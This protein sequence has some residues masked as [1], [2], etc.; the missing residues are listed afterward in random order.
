MLAPFTSALRLPLVATAFLCTVLTV[1]IQESLRPAVTDPY[2]SALLAVAP[3]LLYCFGCV[4]AVAAIRVWPRSYAWVI[5][6]GAPCYELLQ[7]ALAH[8]VFDVFD[9]LVSLVGSGLALLAT[10][11]LDR[12]PRV[13]YQDAPEAYAT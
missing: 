9:L 5:A 2:V 6:S 11:D 7:L 10:R 1:W 4:I 13:V 8:Q 3:S 12:G